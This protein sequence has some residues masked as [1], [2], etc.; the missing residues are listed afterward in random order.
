MS[1]TATKAQMKAD[2]R[3]SLKRMEKQGNVEGQRYFRA[4]LGGWCEAEALRIAKGN[5]GRIAS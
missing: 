2:W 4:L 3:R 5:S 1:G